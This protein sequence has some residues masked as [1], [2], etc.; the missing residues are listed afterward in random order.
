MASP[1][2]GIF[3]T[4]AP[5]ETEALGEA[6]AGVL[7]SGNVVAL[8]G[9]LGAGKTTFTRGIARGLGIEEETTSPTYTIIS[10][11]EGV[12]PLNHIDAYRL[13]GERDFYEIGGEE[14]IGGGGVSVVEWPEKIS[15]A[16]PAESVMVS[17]SVLEDGRREIAIRGLAL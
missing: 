6:L 3:Y 14:V 10:E 7:R 13:G 16:L 1:Y 8:S 9:S 4:G 2:N 5:Y 11:Y 17:I 15:G 12:L